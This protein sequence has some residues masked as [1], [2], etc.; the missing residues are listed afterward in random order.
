MNKKKKSTNELYFITLQP[1]QLVLIGAGLTIFEFLKSKSL[2]IDVLFIWVLAGILET[3]FRRQRKINSNV[4][5]VCFAVLVY[6]VIKSFLVEINTIASKSM[7]PTIP[8][9][10][11]L[12]VLKSFYQ[13]KRGDLIVYITPGEK[14]LRMHRLIGLPGDSIEIKAGSVIINDVQYINQDLP[15]IH[16]QNAGKYGEAGYKASVPSD[17]YYVLGDNNSAD[18]SRYWGFLAKENVKGKCL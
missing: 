18:D 5:S 12:L 10:S 1:L 11:K 4:L 8:I 15:G 9:N 16:Y 17:H 2:S 7:E 13:L 6:F 14:N 3:I